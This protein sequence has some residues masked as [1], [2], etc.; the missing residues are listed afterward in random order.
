MK[1]LIYNSAITLQ[2]ETEYDY[3]E[4][5]EEARTNFYMGTTTVT[6]R[7]W[8]F[9]GPTYEEVVPKK[10]FTIYADSKNVNLSKDWWRA[11]IA[12]KLAAINRA[13]E[14]EKGELI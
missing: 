1:E 3:H 10:V 14:L 12:E 9:Y 4:M 8:G 13:V 7:K 5:G 2:Y 6:K 11:R